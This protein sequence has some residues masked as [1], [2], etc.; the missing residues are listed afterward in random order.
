M[1]AALDG[2]FV[3]YEGL[4]SS[5]L[6]L[7]TGDG[8]ALTDSKLAGFNISGSF[9]SSSGRLTFKYT[10][11]TGKSTRVLWTYQG[12]PV[13]HDAGYRGR[14]KRFWG[15]AGYRSATQSGGGGPVLNPRPLPVAGWW[16]RPRTSY[17]E[18]IQP[19]FR[20]LDI[21]SMRPF[22]LQ[23]DSLD[24]LRDHARAV[25]DA[26]AYPTPSF[27]MPCDGAWPKEWT[28]LFKYWMDDGKPS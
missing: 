5:T 7:V 27:V 3:L 28:T 12:Y 15:W 24:Y 18:D 10:Q 9:K 13:N 11:K 16:A 6:H 26:V 4:K 20:A 25:Y 1:P 23:L 14:S 2:D 8:G 22:G 19:L 17:A 21:D